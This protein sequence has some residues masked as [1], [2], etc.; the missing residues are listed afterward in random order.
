MTNIAANIELERILLQ[1]TG[2]KYHCNGHPLYNDNSR[3]NF[4]QTAN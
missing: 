1:D 3:I 4:R 2:S